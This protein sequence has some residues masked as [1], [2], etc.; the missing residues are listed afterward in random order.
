[1]HGR[2]LMASICLSMM[3]CVGTHNAISWA[4]ASTTSAWGQEG[5]PDEVALLLRAQ[6]DFCVLGDQVRYLQLLTEVLD[7][8]PTQRLGLLMRAKAEMEMGIIDKADGDLKKLEGAVGEMAGLAEARSN[9]W[10]ILGRREE[11]LA[12]LENHVKKSYLDSSVV[13]LQQATAAKDKAVILELK[14][15]TAAAAKAWNGILETGPQETRL[16][17][18]MDYARFWVRQGEYGKAVDQYKKVLDLM[19][20]HRQAGVFSWL[21]TDYAIALWATGARD[22]ARTGFSDAVSERLASRSPDTEVV[23][24]SALGLWVFTRLVGKES[25]KDEAAASWAKVV[26][27]CPKAAPYSLASVVL[28]IDGRA[29]VKDT[30]ERVETALKAAPNLDWA[31][32]SAMHLYLSGAEEAKGLVKRLPEKSIQRRIVEVEEKA[33][34]D[35]GKPF[36]P[37]F[38]P[39]AA[40]KAVP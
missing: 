21:S 10:E 3:I 31:L 24:R 9:Y 30:V 17:D 18:L 27:I 33:A 4:V 1:M 36:P 14:G 28:A 2:I 40:A 7:K 12:V 6:S 35:A 39:P 13:G 8:N 11:R 25:E 23:A 38:V 16:F 26:G 5:Q 15:D 19:E 34:K 20:K 22:L 32:W 29:P 37:K